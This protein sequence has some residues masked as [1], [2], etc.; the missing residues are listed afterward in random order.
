MRVLDSDETAAL[1][2][3]VLPGI[4]GLPRERSEVLVLEEAEESF[5]LGVKD[6]GR[7]SLLVVGV[8]GTDIVWY[9]GMIK[10]CS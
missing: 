5:L 6:T 10:T 2:F 9:D 8:A 3:F 1:N 4:L 7:A